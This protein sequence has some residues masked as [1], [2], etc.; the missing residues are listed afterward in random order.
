MWIRI[1]PVWPPVEECD[2]LMKYVRVNLECINKSYYCLDAFVGYFI[3]ALF[4]SLYVQ[5]FTC[6]VEGKVK[7]SHYTPEMA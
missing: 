1:C 3:T 2:H 4:C 5:C 6:H 7:H